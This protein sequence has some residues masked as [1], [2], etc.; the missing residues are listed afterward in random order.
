MLELSREQCLELLGSHSFGRL[1]V[2]GTR[3]VP[4]IRPVNYFFDRSSQSVIFRT[5][6]GSKL[7]SLIHATQ[8]AFEIDG[9]DPRH[10]TGWSVIIVGVTENV[11]TPSELRRLNE[12]AL[13][14]WAPGEK[15]HW[16]R[17]R[18]ST[19]SGRRISATHAADR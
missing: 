19:V 17:I 16:V 5:A 2:S 10:R 4:V 14:S 9:I 3:G 13:D 6:E 1:A 12:L 8:A 15:S 11:T 18:A 7:H